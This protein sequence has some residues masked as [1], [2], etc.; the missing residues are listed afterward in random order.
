QGATWVEGINGSALKFDGTNDYVELSHPGYLTEGPVEGWIKFDADQSYSYWFSMSVAGMGT[1]GDSM[2]FCLHAENSPNLLFGFYQGGWNWA[3]SGIRPV[4]GEW[5]HVA[6]TWGSAGTRIYVNG[7]LKGTNPYSGGIPSSAQYTYLALNSWGVYFNGTIDEVAMYSR[8]LSPAEIQAH[9][10]Q[11]APV[12][13]DTGFFRVHSNVD[14]ASVYFDQEFKGIIQEGTLL[15]QVYTAATP[16]QNVTVTKA[17]YST[18][19]ESLLGKYPAKDETVDIYALLTPYYYIN[20][21]AGTG[22]SITPSGEVMVLSEGDATFTID[23]ASGYAIDEVLIDGVSNGSLSSYT[24][25]DVLANHTITAQFRYIHTSGGGGDGGGSP[26]P[27]APPEI[28]AEQPPTAPQESPV[29][30]EVT[31]GAPSAIPEPEIALVEET[32]TSL[33]FS[34]PEGITITMPTPAEQQVTIYPLIVG[35]TVS[36]EEKPP[37]TPTEEPVT[38]VTIQQEEMIITLVTQGLTGTPEQGLTGVIESISVETTPVTTTIQDVGQADVYFDVQLATYPEDGTITTT[39]ST[40]DEATVREFQ[41]I[42]TENNAEIAAILFAI[43]VTKT[44]IG[45]TGEATLWATVPK[46]W[47]DSQEG[48][49]ESIYAI[50]I[51]DDG[52]RELLAAEY[53]RTETRA[54]PDTEGNTEFY[55]FKVVSPHGL[56]IFGMISAKAK[57]VSGVVTPAAGATPV[58]APMLVPGGVGFATFLVTNP[59][60]IAGVAV[61]IVV[62]IYMERKFHI[63]RREEIRYPESGLPAW[64]PYIE[65]ER[66]SLYASIIDVLNEVDAQVKELAETL[67]K[68]GIVLGRAETE[69]IVDRFF[70]TCQ[71]AEEKI[72]K[73]ATDGYLTAEQVAQLHEQLG[74]AVNRMIDISRQSPVLAELV[75]VKLG[76]L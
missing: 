24:F 26:A 17:G 19:T 38:I 74:G 35:E 51:G 53:V 65:T 54:V 32:H 23:P 37:A 61:I 66:Q 34:L 50:R 43:D 20:A 42:A 76:V 31:S 11:Y 41:K 10:Q 7:E 1:H 36:Y 62:F 60:F 70:V 45:A 3:D 69:P 21:T 73:G 18:Y 33:D 48:G 2:D 39:I 12:G 72:K 63:F 8:A 56:S 15:V 44:N 9:Y 52:N 71:V 75:Q 49:I 27:A 55:V 13:G 59:I 67:A 25:E 29:I 64:E 6:G 58:V 22:G 5:Y 28:P 30:P 57:E 46:A 47:V 68:P 4:V 16:Y 14:G 40:P